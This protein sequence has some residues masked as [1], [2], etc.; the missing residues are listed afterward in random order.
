MNPTENNWTLLGH[1]QTEF[2]DLERTLKSRECNVKV[3]DKLRIYQKVGSPGWHV[4]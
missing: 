3:N 1:M 4:G 2:R